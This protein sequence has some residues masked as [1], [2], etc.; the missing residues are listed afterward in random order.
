MGWKRTIDILKMDI[1]GGERYLFN[2]QAHEWLSKVKILMIELHD[3][4]YPGCSKLLFQCLGKYN[5][6][7]DIR[8]YTLIIHMDN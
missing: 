2:E 5:Y 8:D 4:Y 1:E 7:L 6:N 3:R